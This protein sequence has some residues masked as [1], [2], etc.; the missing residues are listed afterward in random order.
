MDIDLASNSPAMSFRGFGQLSTW[1]HTRCRQ[2]SLAATQDISTHENAT[3]RTFSH[4]RQD[5]SSITQN[6]PRSA[7]TS[8]DFTHQR[9]HRFRLHGEP[10]ATGV[11]VPLRIRLK[12]RNL[13]GPV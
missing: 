2:I 3:H 6:F 10:D 9:Q 11:I 4:P 5:T 7:R 1:A 13:S 12:A 8:Q